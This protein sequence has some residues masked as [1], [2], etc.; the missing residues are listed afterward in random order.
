MSMVPIVFEIAPTR[1]TVLQR[2]GR[3]LRP[4]NPEPMVAK[5][6]SKW[7]NDI[8]PG[9]MTSIYGPTG[10]GMQLFALR[11]ALK[12]NLGP[13]LYLSSRREMC[14]QAASL[15]AS[16]SAEIETA[17]V[18][19][20]FNTGIMPQARVVIVD[21]MQPAHGVAR[22]VSQMLHNAGVAMLFINY[23]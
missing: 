2:Y 9:K 23:R 22:V 18:Q 7:G 19:R 6:F 12:A 13:V 11:M 4:S 21:E 14:E 15:A 3:A 8:V 16:I 1:N 5:P 10:A 17:T 20:L